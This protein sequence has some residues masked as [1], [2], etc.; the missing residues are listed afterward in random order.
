MKKSLN[1]MYLSLFSIADL[2]LKYNV[3]QSEIKDVIETILFFAWN[4]SVIDGNQYEKMVK[5]SEKDLERFHSYLF[6]KIDFD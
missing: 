1:V 2:A 5:I 6:E 4:D 3:N